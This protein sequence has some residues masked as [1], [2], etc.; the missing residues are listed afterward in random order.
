MLLSC[1]TKVV[2]A[3]CSFIVDRQSV[4]DKSDKGEGHRDGGFVVPFT[5]HVQNLLHVFLISGRHIWHDWVFF[6]LPVFGLWPTPSSS[7]SLPPYY[8]CFGWSTFSQIW[9]STSSSS[10]ISSKK[11]FSNLRIYVTAMSS[12]TS[13]PPYY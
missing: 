11:I 3:I 6:S 5:S 8:Y 10:S 4:C 2:N 9:H 1:C 12:S 13:L 7:T